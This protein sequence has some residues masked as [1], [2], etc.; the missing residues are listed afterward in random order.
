MTVL[1]GSGEIYQPVDLI[2]CLK[3]KIAP[4]MLRGN[5][6]SEGVIFG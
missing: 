2:I 1:E 4:K 3:L 5:L 6:R